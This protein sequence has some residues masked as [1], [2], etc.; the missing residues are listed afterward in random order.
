MKSVVYKKLDFE[1]GHLVKSP[2]H[3]CKQRSEFPGCARSCSILRHIQTMLA[4]T[5]SCTRPYAALESSAIS[6]EGWHK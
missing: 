1:I 2:C 6:L 5:I 3:G 4:E